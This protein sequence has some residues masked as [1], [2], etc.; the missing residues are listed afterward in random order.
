[1]AAFTFA[2]ARTVCEGFAIY[3]LLMTPAI[4]G[5][6]YTADDVL[7]KSPRLDM[8][9]LCLLLCRIRKSTTKVLV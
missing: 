2:I 5:R 6:V 9:V 7:Q 8:D 4:Y 1:M 3:T